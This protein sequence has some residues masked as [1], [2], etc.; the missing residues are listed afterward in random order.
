MK[1]TLDKLFI[2][3]FAI[4]GGLVIFKFI[5]KWL[6]GYETNTELAAIISSSIFI[7]YFIFISVRTHDTRYS[8]LFYALSIV[9]GIFIGYK[10]LDNKELV[11]EL[12]FD[13]LI[14]IS[15][16]ILVHWEKTNKQSAGY[17]M[18][19]DL[20]AINVVEYCRS[21]GN[22]PAEYHSCMDKYRR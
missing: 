4:I 9:I 16:I 1:F 3:A 8:I 17:H 15:I 2:V 19:S 5:S 10:I 13:L 18:P 22:N 12:V 14:P 6:M 20:Q 21:K 11:Y 7:I